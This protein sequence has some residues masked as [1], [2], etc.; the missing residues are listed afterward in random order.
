MKFSF[1]TKNYPT[2]SI[3]FQKLQLRTSLLFLYKALR[4]A[5]KQ[6]NW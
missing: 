4:E 6:H 3:D 5:Q 2:K 1:F